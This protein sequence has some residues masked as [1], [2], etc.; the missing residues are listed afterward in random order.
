MSSSTAARHS[1]WAEVAK[2][3]SA[4]T[5]LSVAKPW[6]QAQEGDRL[7]E[8]LGV[9]SVGQLYLVMA[10]EAG[11]KLVVDDAEVAA[12]GLHT[13]GEVLDWVARSPRSA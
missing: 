1:L 2:V 13:V 12:E 6:A 7:A 8:D 9:D 5:R 11:L 3:L 4:E 10:L